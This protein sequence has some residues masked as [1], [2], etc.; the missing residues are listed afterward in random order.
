MSGTG[1]RTPL[2]LPLSPV[3]VEALGC[4]GGQRYVALWWSPNGNRLMW[5]DG[6]TLGHGNA[7]AWLLLL[8]HP[9]GEKVLGGFDFGSADREGRHA[10]LLDHGEGRVYACTH[11]AVERLLGTESPASRAEAA[12]ADLDEVHEL[13]SAALRGE[14]SR[15]R[16]TGEL[17]AVL[18]RQADLVARLRN[19]LDRTSRN[20]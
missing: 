4:T 11:A 10:L 15:A 7:F 1:D 17:E 9:F 3:L 8:G 13:V 16:A 18:R 14:A 6:A 19:W 2:P 5:W 20:G 12:A